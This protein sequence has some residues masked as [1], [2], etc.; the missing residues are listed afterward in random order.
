MTISNQASGIRPGVCS[1]TTRPTAPFTGQIIYETDTGYLRVWDGSNWDYLTQSQDTT[2]NIKASD[3]GATWTSYTPSL[4][5]GSAVA[6]TVTYAKYVQIGKTCIAVVRLD[7][8]AAGT[9][10]NPIDVGLPV[11]ASQSQLIR[12]GIG[13]FYDAS[14]AITYNG[15]VQIRS[16]TLVSILPDVTNDYIGI[17]PNVALANGDQVSFMIV[18]EVA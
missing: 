17:T 4:A 11:T 7:V 12:I 15:S 18:Y 1:S 3:I 13:T 6:K 14:T 5:Q 16:S 8:T 2:T 10:L 9:T